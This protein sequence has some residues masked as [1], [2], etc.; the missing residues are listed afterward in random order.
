MFLVLTLSGWH[1]FLISLQRAEAP[2]LF[3]I[4]TLCTDYFKTKSQKTIRLDNSQNEERLRNHL[5]WEGAGTGT[6]LILFILP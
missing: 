5:R 2:A 3:P 6:F 4:Y 1:S